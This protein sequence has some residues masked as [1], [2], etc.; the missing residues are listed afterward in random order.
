MTKTA[1]VD[2]YK[3][4]EWSTDTGCDRLARHPQRHM[5]RT[6]DIDLSSMLYE[7]T[8]CSHSR[9]RNVLFSSGSEVTV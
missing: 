3:T 8:P 2:H 9:M 4:R 5:H 6:A 7:A 1:L